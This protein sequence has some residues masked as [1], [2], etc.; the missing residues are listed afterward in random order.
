MS[1]AP[2][3]AIALRRAS[4]ADLAA[5]MDLERTGFAAPEQW[6]EASW[7]GELEGTDRIVLVAAVPAGS[8]TTGAA[9]AEAARPDDAPHGLLGVITYQVGPDTADLMRVVVAPAA[10]GRR[11]GR[12]LVQAGMMYVRGRGVERVLLE[13]RHDNAPAIALYT[14]CGFST[15]A[16]R[17]NYYGPGAD[18]LVMSAPVETDLPSFHLPQTKGTRHD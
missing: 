10:R 16:T 8:S 13:V 5:I 14:G 1:P 2:T 6:S 7:R 12:A 11:V 3:S 9:S 18:A 4:A 15:L 17:T